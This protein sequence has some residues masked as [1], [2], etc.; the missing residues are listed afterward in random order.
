MYVSKLFA[1]SYG[2][3]GL[4]VHGSNPVDSLVHRFTHRV[5]R[6]VLIA[7]GRPDGRVSAMARNEGACLL[8]AMQ[9]AA[10][11]NM[12]T[13]PEIFS[14]GHNTWHG[15]P[16]AIREHVVLPSH[17]RPFVCEF[18]AKVQS[19]SNAPG[20]TDVA[21]V[22]AGLAEGKVVSTHE[23]ALAGHVLCDRCA[24]LPARKECMQCRSSYCMSCHFIVHLRGGE[25]MRDH[26]PLPLSA[27]V[28]MRMSA[29]RAR[30][31]L[32]KRAGVTSESDEVEEVDPAA[33][34]MSNFGRFGAGAG[35]AFPDFGE[36]AA[37]VML[38]GHG[39]LLHVAGAPM[40]IHHA[41]KHLS[42]VAAARAR[43]RWRC[44]G[45]VL[46]WRANPWKA[47][48]LHVKVA[49]AQTDGTPVSDFRA[50]YAGMASADVGAKAVLDAEAV[51]KDIFEGRWA[52]LERYIGFLVLFHAMA[53][54]VSCS[55]WPLPSWDISRSQSIL[56]V[57]STAAPI[58]GAE[59]AHQLAG[60]PA[61]TA[62]TVPQ[63]VLDG[64]ASSAR[65]TSFS[66]THAAAR[67]S[68]APVPD[69]VWELAHAAA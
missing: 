45:R 12:G 28:R 16:S 52:S 53:L 15:N 51:M 3:N 9:A 46:I 33:A 32:L 24:A 54:R 35:A 10:I 4:D 47:L 20:K 59:V 60:E 8:A 40:G 67:V 22:M 6:G 65:T 61:P 37:S 5:Q 64:H 29:Q 34:A 38:K 21:S 43:N 18:L 66:G 26:T 2:D 62:F 19:G 68:V 49:S 27:A 63:R 11:Q 1:L 31:R 39:R 50:L 57:A 23:L 56:R 58:S 36:Q 25:A 48:I 30:E 42:G 55:S 41:R 17:R 7:L 44:A 13:G 14:V 69:A